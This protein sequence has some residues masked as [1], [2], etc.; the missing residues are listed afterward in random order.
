MQLTSRNEGV[1]RATRRGAAMVEMAMVLPVF[2]VLLLGIVEFGRAF[3]VY[4]MVVAAAREGARKAVI[5]EKSE[6]D[7]LESISKIVTGGGMS[8]SKFT[9]TVYV[10]GQAAALSTASRGDEIRV[11]LSIPFKEVAVCTPR[12]I[13]GTSTVAADCTMRK[14]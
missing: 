8:M 11:A 3:M 9:V 5:P 6:A 12:Y 4:E 7:V 1:R 13:T 14:E 2:T 10:N